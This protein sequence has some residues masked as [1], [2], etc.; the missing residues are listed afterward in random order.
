MLVLS[1]SFHRGHLLF[2]KP[3]HLT[4]TSILRKA[5]MATSNLQ[6]M[7]TNVAD[8]NFSNAM[9]YPYARTI[10]L[11]KTPTRLKAMDHNL[12]QRLV[13]WGYAVCDAALR[14]QVYP[15]IAVL[16]DFPFP[17]AAV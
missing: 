10:G 16:P 12:K 1:T 13:N 9:N 2:S 5:P 7:R 6:P 15:N 17:V 11:V 8:D 4:Q 3:T 14:K